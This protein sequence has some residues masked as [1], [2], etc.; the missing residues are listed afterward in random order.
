MEAAIK[1]YGKPSEILAIIKSNK[2]PAPKV[3][4][5]AYSGP[6]A[7]NVSLADKISS[8]PGIGSDLIRRIAVNAYIAGASDMLLSGSA[9]GYY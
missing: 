6:L 2:S 5:Y 1:N 3:G 4:L 9:S 7:G 8:I